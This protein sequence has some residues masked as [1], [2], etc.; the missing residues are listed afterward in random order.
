MRRMRS[1]E[2]PLGRARRVRAKRAALGG[3]TV[4][5]FGLALLFFLA[6][7]ERHGPTPPGR[8][9]L[10]LSRAQATE[11]LTQPRLLSSSQ[12][13]MIPPEFVSDPPLL[14]LQSAPPAKTDPAVQTNSLNSSPESP[15][16]EQPTAASA[17]PTVPLQLTPEPT[18]QAAAGPT[19]PGSVA[20]TVE[21]AGLLPAAAPTSLPPTASLNDSLPV[22]DADEQLASRAETT[23]SVKEAEAVQPYVGT[24]AAH[25]SACLPGNTKTRY[26]PLT[27]K[28]RAAR[29]GDG[30]CSFR[31]LARHGNSWKIEASCRSKGESWESQ[32]RLVLAGS[33]LTWS[34]KRG[35][36]TYHRC[37]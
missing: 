18:M 7:P 5:C 28:E 1:D 13:M 25:R 35:V 10:E 14:Q 15:G 17:D 6:G 19:I 22:P 31:K 26:I 21:S 33:K 16:G 4:A 30:S 24:W 23:V 8:A 29:A 27:L 37:S 3:S 11:P 32:V 12:L 36:Q 2:Y 20:T 9:T 34:S